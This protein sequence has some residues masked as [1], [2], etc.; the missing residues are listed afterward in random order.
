[1]SALFITALLTEAVHAAGLETDLRRSSSLGFVYADTRLTI[2]VQHEAE[3]DRV[4]A[5]ISNADRGLPAMIL[6]DP[7]HV[8]EF[9]NILRS[10]ITF[11]DEGK[12]QAEARTARARTELKATID[13]AAS[14]VGFDKHR[15]DPGLGVYIN[16]ES[17]SGAN[18]PFYFLAESAVGRL[19]FLPCTEAG[20]CIEGARF[21]TSSHEL[22]SIFTAIEALEA[23]W[24]KTLDK[25]PQ[26]E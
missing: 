4:L 21:Y 22:A 15:E 13:A 5:Q 26:P 19:S 10:E 12:A 20:D 2:A 18:P 1:M 8:Q 23:D 6:E 14:R 17:A 3:H 16:R 9:A 25:S 24:V 7:Q 11:A